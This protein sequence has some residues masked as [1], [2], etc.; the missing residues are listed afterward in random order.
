MPA[1]PPSAVASSSLFLG[2]PDEAVAEVLRA[3]TVRQLAAGEC[4]FLQGEAVE[5][6]FVV[7]SGL[8]RLSQ[9]T[10]EGEEVIVRTLGAGE[11]VAGVAL[12][13]K[14]SY[15]VSAT[16]ETRCRVL[17]WARPRIHELAG[18]YPA[19]RTNVL[20]T[21]A[22][23]MQ[24]S[25]SRIRELATESA[26]QR[27]ARALVR[28]ARE[29]GRRVEGGT[30]IDQPLGRQQ[31][32]DLSGASMFTASRLLAAWARDGVLEVGRQRVVVRSLERLERLAGGD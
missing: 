12:L 27:V 4:L 6:L 10:P 15:P 16:C 20:A 17:A 1:P 24:A 28:L 23:R 22:D 21:I 5:A 2:L 29:H 13:E 19:L 9:H 30:L 26:P 18:R 3:A 7:E 14:R 31:L 25:L 32:A 8:L 11:I